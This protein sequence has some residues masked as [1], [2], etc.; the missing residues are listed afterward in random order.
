MQAPVC[1]ICET[2]PLRIALLLQLEELCEMTGGVYCFMAAVELPA[3]TDSFDLVHFSAGH[4]PVLALLEQ[5][6]GNL[7][8]ET[9]AAICADLNGGSHIAK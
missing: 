8:R 7:R 9:L 5:P 4:P 2:Q 1:S 6:S 3:S